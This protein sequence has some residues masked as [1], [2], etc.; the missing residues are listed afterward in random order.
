MQSSPATSN[1][2]QSSETSSP[3]SWGQWAKQSLQSN[4]PLRVLA[5]AN[6]GRGIDVLDR[7]QRRAERIAD[8][9]LASKTDQES[10][11]GDG[12][13]VHFGDVQ[14]P[15]PIVINGQQSS[16]NDFLK[17]LAIAALGAAIPGAGIAGYLVNQAIS[18]PTPIAQ[19]VTPAP[20]DQNDFSV[21]LGKIEDY[22]K[23][24]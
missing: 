14:Q 21:G 16:G 3:L 24:D 12:M 2:G 17:G 7:N 15:Q 20:S 11:Q 19:P 13:G 5:V 18:K 23:Q 8:T 22:L 1:V 4:N 9:V 6:M 10:E